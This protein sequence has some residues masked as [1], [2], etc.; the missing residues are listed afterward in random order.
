[1]HYATQRAD[2]EVVRALIEAGADV[3][4]K[5]DKGMSALQLA[6]MEL[7]SYNFADQSLR[8]AYRGRVQK[9]ID[10][11]AASGAKADHP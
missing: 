5:D 9:V 1:M 8:D 10:L 3:N 2:P 7:R 4:A 11:L 6:N